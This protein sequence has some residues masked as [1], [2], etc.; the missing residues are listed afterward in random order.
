MDQISFHLKPLPPFDLRFTAWALRRR[1][2]NIVD[3]WDGQAYRRVMAYDGKPVEVEITQK[4]TLDRPILQVTT[5]AE[6]IVPQ[7]KPSIA[8]ALE[9]MMGLRIDLSK[10]YEFAKGEKR[11]YELSQRF[12]GLKPPRFPSLFE[13]LVN[14]FACQQLTLTVGIL[15]L[16]RLAMKAGLPFKR[17]ESTVYAFPQP[18]RV[19]RLHLE[20]FRNLGFSRQKGRALIELSQR[21][22]RKSVNLNRIEALDDEA[23][24]E[25]LYQLRGV[26]RWSAEY[27]LLRGMGRLN[28][29]PGDDVGAQNKLR[30]LLNLRKPLD[31][32]GV[33]RILDRW[34]P[35]GGLVYF[36]LLLEGLR[37]KGYLQ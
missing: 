16:N 31:Y 10:F 1:S 7:L 12:V 13:A 27:V 30:H 29:F 4:G 24:L 21:V 14:A 35:F 32:E 23:A 17:G 3:R 37:E 33:R 8:R 2:E 28:L 22:T 18:E 9:R 36:H 26:G 19:E 5:T 11:L 15:L 25:Q 6:K 20:T 34:E